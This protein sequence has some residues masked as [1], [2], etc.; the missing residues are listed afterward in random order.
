MPRITQKLPPLRDGIPCPV[1][2]A[3]GISLGL[4]ISVAIT[5]AAIWLVALWTPA[6]IREDLDLALILLTGVTFLTSLAAMGSLIQR[7]PRLHHFFS[8]CA[9]DPE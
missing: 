3:I 1:R 7:S 4:A 9:D 5:R 6:E 8:W 2:A